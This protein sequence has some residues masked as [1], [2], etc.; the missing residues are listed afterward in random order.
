MTSMNRMAVARTVAT[1]R[2]RA[3]SVVINTPAPEQNVSPTIRFKEEEQIV[4][5]HGVRYADSNTSLSDFC[6]GDRVFTLYD[7]SNASYVDTTDLG[8]MTVE[9]FLALDN[10]GGVIEASLP[11]IGTFTYQ[12]LAD[13]LFSVYVA[14]AEDRAN[15]P[16]EPEPTPSPEDANDAVTEPAE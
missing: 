15:P 8:D 2:R 16:P 11:E 14:L 6:D 7:T 10:N 13:I 12:N 1:V 5:S 3:G 9:D 4:D